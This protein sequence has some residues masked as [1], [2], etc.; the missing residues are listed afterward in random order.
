MKQSSCCVVPNLYR[1]IS[2]LGHHL[3]QRQQDQHSIVSQIATSVC[4]TIQHFMMLICFMFPGFGYHAEIR[5]LPPHCTQIS[6]AILGC[7][8]FWTDCSKNIAKIL[9][10]LCTFDVPGDPGSCYSPAF[11]T[12][13]TCSMARLTE[14]N[15]RIHDTFKLF[16]SFC[17]DI[18]ES[19]HLEIAYLDQI[20][21]I[22]YMHE[23]CLC[24]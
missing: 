13:L 15:R 19:F 9:G 21:H 23:Y 11:T 5:K 14:R 7:S 1:P 4:F 24:I 2:E 20:K 6:A 22:L 10:A 18:G 12:A 8:L 17:M 3:L 16:I